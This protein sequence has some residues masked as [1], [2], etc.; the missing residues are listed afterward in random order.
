M[1]TS[2]YAMWTESLIP[3]ALAR[4]A[5]YAFNRKYGSG[6][7][8]SVMNYARGSGGGPNQ[9]PR[10]KHVAGLDAMNRSKLG[11]GHVD[12]VTLTEDGRRAG[13][14]ELGAGDERRIDLVEHL[15]QG[16]GDSRPQILKVNLP[17]QQISL[18]P[19]SDAAGNP[20]ESLAP[21]A[22]KRAAW[23]GQA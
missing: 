18:F 1:Q 7:V 6:F 23:S 13:P 2:D 17:S 4:A 22:R 14:H 20:H 9:V 11:W 3:N 12:E 10:G 5:P 15:G 21:P 8:T 19:H 16:Q